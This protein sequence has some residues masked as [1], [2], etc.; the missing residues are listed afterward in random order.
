MNEAV[1]KGIVQKIRGEVDKE[2]TGVDYPALYFLD[3][4]ETFKELSSR[5]LREIHRVKLA[6]PGFRVMQDG[7]SRNH[8]EP[9][10]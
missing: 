3:E 7:P 10:A 8:E 2:L 6:Y 1:L 4:I 5:D 9:F